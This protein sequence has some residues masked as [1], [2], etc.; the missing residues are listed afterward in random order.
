LTPARVRHARDKGRVERAVAVVR[1]DCFA[2]EVLAALD[3]ARALARHWCL[4]DYGLRPHS[5]TQR[6][7]L[8][9]F[10]TEEQP[11]LLH[12][13]TAPY[14]I[15]LWSEPKVARDQLAAIGKAFYSIPHRYVGHTLT[16]R[17]DAHLVR[18]Y[19]GSLLIKT[20]PRKAP[21]PAVD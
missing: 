4:E 5:R 17:A 11:V 15:P 1:D 20:H 21:G 14:D 10:Q 19:A 16:A 8:E 6:R 9:H 13:P 18:F 3:D 2:G 12:A 7:P